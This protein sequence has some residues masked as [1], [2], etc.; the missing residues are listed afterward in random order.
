MDFHFH[1][2]WQADILNDNQKKLLHEVESFNVASNFREF[3][4]K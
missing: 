4:D 2:A 3:V 1:F